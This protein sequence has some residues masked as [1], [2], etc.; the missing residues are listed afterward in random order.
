MRRYLY[1]FPACVGVFC[2][3]SVEHP[4]FIG[5]TFSKENSHENSSAETGS[6]AGQRD[7]L[8]TC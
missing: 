8:G 2:S 7:P 5:L 3:L 6:V 1:V 4:D